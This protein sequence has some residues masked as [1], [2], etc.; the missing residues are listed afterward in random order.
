LIANREIARRKESM[1]SALPEVQDE[2][3]YKTR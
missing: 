3:R 2:V 1:R